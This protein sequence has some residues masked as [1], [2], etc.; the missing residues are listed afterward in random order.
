MLT[1]VV[2]LAFVLA[3]AA[4]NLILEAL[5][6]WASPGVSFVLVGMSMV[7]RDYL[8]DRWSRAG[9]FPV[10]MG[11]II[12]AAGALAYLV[13][14]AAGRIAVASVAA[15]V[16]SALAE[17]FVFHR[18]IRRRWMVRS[19]VSNAA[20]ALLDT[21]TFMVVAFGPTGE[22]LLVAAIS[23]TVKL[24]GGFAWASLFRVTINPDARREAA[25]TG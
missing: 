16:V 7:A 5:G 9:G 22:S 14:P 23:T 3:M 20:G 15:L 18:A 10:R 17:T 6:P 4:A 24:V 2:A 11:A 12:A 21:V 1:A 13:N 19:N 25:A 8:H